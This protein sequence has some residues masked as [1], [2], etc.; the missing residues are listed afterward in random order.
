VMVAGA[1]SAVLA[2]YEQATGSQIWGATAITA[3]GGV[4]IQ[5]LTGTLSNPTVLG[6]VT[7]GAACVAACMLVWRAPDP[8]WR[9]AAVGTL[10]VTLPVT[11]LTY[12]RAPMVATGIGIVIVVAC[13]RRAWNAAIVT[14]LGVT[15]AGLLAWGFLT[16]SSIY[17]S[18]V[19]DTGTVQTRLELAHRSVQL[20]G[21]HPVFG[22]GYRSFDEVKN[23]PSGPVATPLEF[24][25]TSHNTFLTYLVELGILG[26]ALLLS[27]WGW[28]LWRAFR[29]RRADR[30]APWLTLGWVVLLVVYV[31]NAMLI[32]MRF[33]SYVA[34]LPWIA[35]GFLRRT[36]RDDVAA[37][38]EPRVP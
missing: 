5:T 23:L 8:W 21:E 24:V 22:T 31:V 28:V 30:G 25:D 19:S 20:F 3:L 12:E 13:R 33:Y 17:E 11:F 14:A 10:V 27:F 1:L 2:L 15:L 29:H 16:S 26:L 32:D 4:P 34:V 35:L 37:A 36:S 38:A 9:R 7:G 18:R 6:T